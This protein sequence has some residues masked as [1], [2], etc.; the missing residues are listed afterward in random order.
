M[1]KLHGIYKMLVFL[2][3]QGVRERLCFSKVSKYILDCVPVSMR[4]TSASV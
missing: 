4:H 1:N 3:I 2:T